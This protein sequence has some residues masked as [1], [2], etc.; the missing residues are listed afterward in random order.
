[1]CCALLFCFFC[2]SVVA[3]TKELKV[4]TFLEQRKNIFLNLSW[5][6]KLF[7]AHNINR[8]RER[9]RERVKKKKKKKKKQYGI[10]VRA[11][12]WW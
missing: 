12:L 7:C 8:E 9:E 2:C 4:P 5:I 10:D 3:K 11:F 1:M 6:H